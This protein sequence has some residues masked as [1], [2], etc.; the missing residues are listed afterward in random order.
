MGWKSFC[1]ANCTTR[2]AI[3]L[4]WR[5]ELP[6]AMTTTSVMSVRCRTSS[7]LTLTAFMSSSAVLTMR[8]RACGTAGLAGAVARR[9]RALVGIALRGSANGAS[10]AP[11]LA[12]DLAHRV[13]NQEAR[14]PSG[15]DDLAQFRGRDLE[16]SDRVHVDASVQRAMQVVHRARATVDHELAQ[17]PLR[18]RAP[19][20]PVRHHD[21]REVE[22]LAPAVPAGQA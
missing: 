13:G 3:D 14:I 2:S 22:E 10:I 21:V 20:G 4:T 17:R 19:A 16:L 7:T 1:L 8:S 11:G 5:S 12:N 18:G 15:I 6:E 9:G